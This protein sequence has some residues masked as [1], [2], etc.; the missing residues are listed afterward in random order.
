VEAASTAS[1]FKLLVAVWSGLSTQHARSMSA[2]WNHCLQGT[3][4]R[5]PYRPSGFV[6]ATA[7]S[8][9]LISNT[10]LS[11]TLVWDPNSESDLAGYRIYTG[12]RSR[13][14]SSIVDVGNTTQYPLTNLTQGTTYYLALTAYNSAGLESDFSQEISYTPASS[15]T[16]PHISGLT[17]RA[18]SEDTSAGPI[19]FT[20]GDAETPNSLVLGA[21]SSNP[22]LVPNGSIVLGGS[23]TNRTLSVTPAINQSGSATITVSVSDGQLSASNSFVLTVN[24]VND[25]PTIANTADRTIDQNTSTG[26]IGFTVG[27]VETAAGSLVLSAGSSNPLLVPVQN[28]VFGGSGSSRTVNVSPATNQT[29]TTTI[30]VTVSDGERSATDSWVL[31]V[32]ATATSNTPP[33]LSTVR[34]TTIF[35][36]GTSLPMRFSVLDAES[37]PDTLRVWGVSSNPSLIAESSILFQGSGSNRT[38][39]VTAANLTGTAT[40]TLNAED[41]SGSRASTSF[42]VTVVARPTQL[43]YLPFEAEAGAIVS[44]MRRYTNGSVVHV[45]TTS[46]SQGT[47]T[48]QFSITEPGNYI[49]WARHLSPDNSRDSFY[50]AVDGVEIAYPTAIGTWS[51][52]WQW[53]R[54]TAPG[55]GG[56]QDPR[57]LNLATGTHT[58]VFRGNEAQCALDRIVICNDLEVVP[59]ATDVNTPPVISSIPDTS[60]TAGTS[61][62][63]PIQV[64]DDQT[65]AESLVLSATSSDQALLPTASIVF[66]GNGTSRTVTATPVSGS[67]GSVNVTVMVSD[68]ELSASENFLLTVTSGNTPPSISTLS[69]RVIHEDTGTGPVS[70]SVN[71]AESPNALVVSTASSNPTLVPS[72]SMILGGSGTNRTLTV[73]PAL[74]QSGSATIT[75]SVSDGQLS[76]S[77][78]FVLTVNPVNDA[79]SIANI[80]DRTIDQNTSTGPIAFTIGDVETAA[81]NL[82]LSADSS[83]PTLVSLQNIVFGGSDNNRTVNVTSASNQTGTATISVTVSDGARSASDSW[84]LTVRATATSHTPPVLSTVRSTTIFSGG[85]SLPL[86]F[87]V[88]DAQSPPDTLRVWAVSSNPSLIPESNIAFEGS[89]SNRTLTVTAANL[90]GNATITLNA[91][92]SSG[93]RTSTT[94]GVT[95]VARPAQLVYLPF[96]AEAGTVV[97][98]MKRYIDSP[99]TYVTSTSKQHGSVSFDFSITEPGNYIIWARHLSPNGGHD[100]FFVSM[101]GIEADYQTTDTWSMNWQWTRVNL[102]TSAGTTTDPRV[103]NLSAGTHQLIF[104]AQ[105]AN[106]PLDKLI[107]CN[108]LDFVPQDGSSFAATLG[109]IENVVQPDSVS[110]TRVDVIWE[111]TPGSTYKVEGKVSDSWI[112]VSGDITSDREE[113]SWTAPE[114]S[115]SFEDYRVIQVE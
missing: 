111:S 80:A 1:N 22:T 36:G 115:E 82:V 104:R 51:T 113:T 100:S 54:V 47:V 92:D 79:P 57:V 41:S 99:V 64:G 56:T 45:A 59:A 31:T 7:F 33:V 93:G 66:G 108:D 73:S 12:V 9:L 21:L 110:S 62:T 98:P 114:P 23:G 63:L 3:L 76:A 30:S 50:V 58:V 4:G 14:Y 67:S 83:N 27:D 6:N 112:D 24:A 75:V 72:G 95:V 68:G 25:A 78:S 10:A 103:F 85:T 101:D 43:A 60:V 86:R 15:N 5:R 16:P 69:D 20:V 35:S 28:I 48:F 8:L 52:N 49:I 19:G 74:N 40:I 26:P 105:E 34:S 2:L 88:S 106:C 18:I 17:D 39:T 38:L 53:T 87:S 13:E 11:A 109:S 29:G 32:R 70:F 71:D 96:E 97:S 107:I 84:M 37:P 94:F 65:A 46:A 42:G 102:Q 89:G 44:P 61:R 77:N 81:S 55:S 90:T 91:E